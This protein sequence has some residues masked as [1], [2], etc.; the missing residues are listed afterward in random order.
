MVSLYK[1]YF[2]LFALLLFHKS[3]DAQ[4]YNFSTYSV[5][6]GLGQSTINK[7]TQDKYGYLW[8]ATDGGLS[9]FNGRDFK[10]FTKENG[11]PCNKIN[12]ILEFENKL[13]I[14]TERGLVIYD[15]KSFK[16]MSN[17]SF[18]N[19]T[20]IIEFEK[21]NDQ[22]IVITDETITVISDKLIQTI[23]AQ[24]INLN[25]KITCLKID[26]DKNIWVGSKSDGIFILLFNPSSILNSDFT[27]NNLTGNF[28]FA[29]KKI[30]VVL[31]NNENGLIGNSIN[32]IE[33]DLK[34]NIWY[35]E[36][37]TGLGKISFSENTELEFTDY[38]V[39]ENNKNPFVTSRLEAIYCDKDGKI[40]IATDG[41]GVYKISPK[42]KFYD[43]DLSENNI[44][45][46]SQANG[47]PDNNPHCFFADN[48]NN[49]WIGTAGNGIVKLN[50]EK[51]FSYGKENGLDE[52]R[53]ISIY[54]DT[55]DDELWIGTYGGG[56][57]NKSKNSFTHYFWD[58]GISETVVTGI[59]KDS[60]KNIWVATNGGGISILPFENRKKKGKKFIYIN[61]E[62]GLPWEFMTC[63][64]I[65]YNNNI[66]AGISNAGGIV[67]ITN[68]KEFKNYKTEKICQQEEIL[69]ADVNTIFVDKQN[70]IWV[71]TKKG[72]ISLNANGAV[73]SRFEKNSFLKEKEI[74]TI[75]QDEI[76][77]IWLGSFEDGII[78]L[79]NNTKKS[80]L[81]GA[82]S[83]KPEYLTTANGISSNSIKGLIAAK[84]MIIATTNAGFSK[85]LFRDKSNG[86]SSI[87]KFT[88]LDGFAAIECNVNA[89][90]VDKQ[91]LIWI[92]GS[93][94]LTAFVNKNDN[95]LNFPPTLN[96]E[97]ILIDY[98]NLDSANKPN[99]GISFSNV[100]SWFGIPQNLLLDYDKNNITFE[101]AGIS[102]SSS[103]QV[104][105]QYMMEGLDKRWSPITFDNNVTFS[106]LPPGG[107]TFKLKAGSVDNIWSPEPLSY[108]FE[109]KPPFFKTI[110][111]Y[112]LSILGAIGLIT[113]F[114]QLKIKNL[115][116][117]KKQLELK[118][119]ERTTEVEKQKEEIV[120]KSRII[121]LKN[122]DI[123]AGIRY[124][125]RIQKAILPDENLLTN[126]FAEHFIFFKPRD[127]VSGDF[128][129]IAERDNK[130][131]IAA[132]DC[133]G[134]GV[135]GA[136]MSLI[137]YSLMNEALLLSNGNNDQIL[138]IL[139]Q[140]LHKA[141]KQNDP[142]ALVSDGLDIAL[143]SYDKQNN[144]LEFS[145]SNRPLYLMRKNELIIIDST[146]SVIGGNYQSLDET[147]KIEKIKMLLGDKV[148]L[149]TDGY[150][151]QFGGDKM[152]KFG[153]INFQ[154]L[155]KEISI[156]NMKTALQ[157]VSD[158]LNNW[159]MK[160]DQ[161]DDILVIGL[162]I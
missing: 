31:L 150:T 153:K 19:T 51:F 139:R 8:L 71:A 45:F 95:K 106:S 11:L 62:N 93:A 156:H 30:E 111:F 49:M 52:P 116:E 154:N 85:I 15:G 18:L 76:G 99:S 89:L 104:R 84:G 121:E 47:L 98:N 147:F 7:I 115:R 88:D 68:N 132:I 70:R 38:S 46:Y 90:S 103:E 55:I 100:S 151:D 119:S 25:S 138:T 145:N 81:P 155:I 142:E 86:I 114:I 135:S 126:Y 160:S 24:E 20:K 59:V 124:A 35:D 28:K 50:N 10:N 112:I 14:G 32:C 96:F 146:R 161:I 37:R 74:T 129:W 40:W 120:E 91:N 159:Q 102:T 27:K 13:W 123:T 79:K 125:E 3:G 61:A 69:Q 94:G 97:K 128:Y 36:W 5:N 39:D 33:Q 1:R 21:L 107:Y 113:L 48:E 72:V 87:K 6:E 133:T 65:D 56:L 63:I 130:V 149:F 109:I 162:M 53:V 67:R 4:N 148:Y 75:C 42:N 77:N 22:L 83:Y 134:H 131:Y 16:K 110:R 118:V 127:I 117:S 2:F 44:G 54:S 80:Y 78:I 92:G 9:Q 140:N 144:D 17:S 137:S 43:Y 158:N 143:I 23:T 66:W 12:C 26:N 58:D 82:D 122:E 41:F 108:S 157:L 136:F 64:T 73:I 141:L 57:F 60:F 34:N 105:Y 101:Y 152:K 29:N